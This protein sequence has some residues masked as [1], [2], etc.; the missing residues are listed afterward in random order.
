MKEIRK[1][2][3]Y[4]QVLSKI[5]LFHGVGPELSES[6]YES[7]QCTCAE[8]EQGEDIYT[9]TD[10]QRSIGIV[11]SGGLKAIK[12]G[13]Q[14]IVL[15]TFESGGIFGVAG[16]FNS[17]CHYVSEIVA[18]RRSRVLFLPQALLKDL[19][20]REPRVAENYITFLS[21]RIRFLNI[22]IDH[23]TGGSA[24]ARIAHFL[25][26][27]GEGKHGPFELPCSLTQLS[28]TLGIGRA[29]LYRALG[30]L[31]GSGLIKRSG[32]WVEI[33]DPE[34]LKNARF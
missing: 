13:G 26:A 16:L 33:L 15:N 30:T 7:S 2:K 5:F 34:G 3:K 22:C 6:A 1:T 25:V 27:L 31:V 23:F 9:R 20:Y 24:E 8:F 21:G 18:T 19:I 4:G 11:L 17:S 10:F 29:S 28:D 14:G 12:G 32:R